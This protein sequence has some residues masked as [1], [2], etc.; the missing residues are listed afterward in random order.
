LI[1]ELPQD[2]NAEVIREDDEIE[3]VISIFL[4]INLPDFLLG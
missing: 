2:L 3:V 1:A 4:S